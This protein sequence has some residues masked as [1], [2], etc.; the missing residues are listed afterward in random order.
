MSTTN[1]LIPWLMDGD[2]A[3]CWQTKRDLE[4]APVKRWQA[5]QRRA[6]NEGWGARLLALQAPDGSWCGGIYSPKWT[7]TTYTLLSYPHRRHYDVLRGLEYFARAN[8]PRDERLRDAID[9]LNSRRGADGTWPVQ[10]K[11]PGKVFFQMEQVGRPSRWNTLRAL[12]VLQWW[13]R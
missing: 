3:I 1:G 11:Y 2:P 10:H 6:L 8:A 5:E 9:L 13:E 4:D 7:S 12:R